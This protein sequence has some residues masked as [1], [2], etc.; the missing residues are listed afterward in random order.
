MTALRTRIIGALAFGFVLVFAFAT[1]MQLSTELINFITGF[2]L[3]FLFPGGLRLALNDMGQLFSV[4]GSL[5]F[6]ALIVSALFF[7]WKSRLR[8]RSLIWDD[9]DQD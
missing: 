9:E 7:V 2:Q 1:F 8:R 6:T 4:I 3:R 5:V